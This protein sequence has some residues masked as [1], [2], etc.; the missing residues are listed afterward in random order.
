MF[1][2]GKE[3]INGLAELIK[4]GIILDRDLFERLESGLGS[5]KSLDEEFIEEAV[6]RSVSIK[7]GVVEKD[8]EDRDYRNV[9]NFGHT[10][11]HAL[12]TVSA[13]EIKHGSGVA[14]GMA[15]ATLISQ[16]MGFLAAPE[17]H[18]IISVLEGA[19]LPT[20]HAVADIPKIIQAMQYDKK[21]AGGKIRFVLLRDIGEVFL[22]EDVNINLVEQVLKDLYV[23]T[24]YMRGHR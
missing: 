21:R 24:P 7:A 1:P 4:H 18:R 5:L 8:E 2:P 15:A 13:F 10:V 14:I 9:L 3:F 22:S 16:R 6:Y 12:E 19:G 11:G 20:R 17:M 23:E